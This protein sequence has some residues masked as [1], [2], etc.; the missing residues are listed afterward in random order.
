[1][2]GEHSD[3]NYFIITEIYSLVEFSVIVLAYLTFSTPNTISYDTIYIEYLY[4]TNV[5]DDILYVTI[6]TI[7][8]EIKF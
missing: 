6:Y 3:S 7:V 1:M 8:E 5:S 4:Q 2:G